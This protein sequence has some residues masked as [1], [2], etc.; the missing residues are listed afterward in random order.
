MGDLVP[1]HRRKTDEPNVEASQAVLEAY[2]I[3]MKRNLTQLSKLLGQLE[4]HV[5]RLEK[6][7]KQKED[8]SN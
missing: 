1:L 3:A 6:T 4:G 7:Y 2:R 8:N 5:T